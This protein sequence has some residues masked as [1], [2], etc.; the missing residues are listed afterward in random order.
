MRCSVIRA[1]SRLNSSSPLVP[2]GPFVVRVAPPTG[3]SSA[4]PSAIEESLGE[5]VVVAV[6]ALTAEV[7]IVTYTV[8]RS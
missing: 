1:S 6:D 7:V 5:D 3:Y 2:S 4:T 8:S